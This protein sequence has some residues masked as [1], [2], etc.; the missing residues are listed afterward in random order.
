MKQANLKSSNK[1]FKPRPKMENF[2]GRTRTTCFGSN[3][4]PTVE[5]FIASYRKIL[6]STEL[7]CSS[8][9]NCV[10]KLNMLQVSSRREAQIS[11]Q[12]VIVRDFGN[13]D[14]QTNTRDIQKTNESSIDLLKKV[15]MLD[16]DPE[17]ITLSSDI[18]I[19]YLAGI[20]EKKLSSD[21]RFKCTDCLSMIPDILRRNTKYNNPHVETKDSQI[22]SQ[23]TF[24]IY[25]VSNDFFTNKC[26]ENR[27]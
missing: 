5:Q 4:N 8:L 23:S 19:S 21:V 9:S 22:P 15:M 16:Q 10:D 7:T 25:K 20:I 1:K 17:N 27:F 18:T 13:T 14:R 24:D 6:L 26:H 2:F 11:I 3:D 12:P